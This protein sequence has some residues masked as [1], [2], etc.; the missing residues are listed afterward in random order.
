MSE[1]DKRENA[2]IL[3]RLQHTLKH[4]ISKD[5]MMEIKKLFD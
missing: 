4:T 5:N 2:A 3:E 1:A